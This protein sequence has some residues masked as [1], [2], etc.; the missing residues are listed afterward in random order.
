MLVKPRI[1]MASPR[2]GVSEGAINETGA[3]VSDTP[4]EM[5]IAG[6]GGH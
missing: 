5:I 3:V 2:Q 6:D 1:V 4:R